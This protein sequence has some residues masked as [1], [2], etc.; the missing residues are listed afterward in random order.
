MNHR[1]AVKTEL[2]PQDLDGI[3]PEQLEQHWKLYEGYVKNVNALNERLTALS[4]KKDF[5]VEF[6]ELKR[7]LGFEY[8]GMILH[9]HYFGV[10]KKGVDLPGEGSELTKLLKKSFGGYKA[11]KEEFSA[12]GKMRGV[13]WAILYYDP[14]GGVLS[15][16]WIG[17]H[18]SGHP[19]GFVPVLVMDVW[20]HAFMVDHGA[21]GR[22][23][24]IEAFFRNVDWRKVET[25]LK[26]ARKAGD[27]LA[28]VR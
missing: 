14:R 16:H 19:A 9:E 26:D 8:D 4:E 24:Y 18:E 15:N 1:Y 7:R 2:R 20:E 23:D 11:W 25:A 17:L 13:G 6:S 27:V 10:L 21:S 3:G 12:V 28:H 22:P 5:G